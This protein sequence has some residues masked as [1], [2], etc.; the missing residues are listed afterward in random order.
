MQESSNL[1][2]STKMRRSSSKKSKQ[3]SMKKQSSIEESMTDVEDREILESTQ[4]VN[5]QITLQ[6]KEQ[7]EQAYSPS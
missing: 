1:D 2:S 4:S 6:D 3:S 7:I 5:W